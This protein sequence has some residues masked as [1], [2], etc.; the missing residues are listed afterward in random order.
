[1]YKA[2]FIERFQWNE[3][4]YIL[5]DLH[6]NYR[7]RESGL[8]TLEREGIIVLSGV[9]KSAKGHI[10]EVLRSNSLNYSISSF[11]FCQHSEEKS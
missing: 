8:L 10:Y 11:I 3:H 2:V 6:S 9:G 7:S 4:I 5:Q 1:M